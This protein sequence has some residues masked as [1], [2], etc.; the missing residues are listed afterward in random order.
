MIVDCGHNDW[1]WFDGPNSSNN[2]GNEP[3][4]PPAANTFTAQSPGGRKDPATW[5]DLSGNLWLFGGYG[6]ENPVFTPTLNQ[7][8]PLNDLWEYVGTQNYFGSFGNYWTNLI[9]ANP[10]PSS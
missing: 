8:Q 4:A 10:S 6:M 3:G 7:A 2:N 9:P 5:T 1:A